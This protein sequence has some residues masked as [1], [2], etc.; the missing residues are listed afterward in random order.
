MHAPLNKKSNSKVI[1]HLIFI[2]VYI[3]QLRIRHNKHIN[4]ENFTIFRTK[5][6]FFLF[7]DLGD[8]HFVAVGKRGSLLYLSL[9]GHVCAFKN[10]KKWILSKKKKRMNIVATSEVRRITHTNFRH[11]HKMIQIQ[12]NWNESASLL[13]MCRWSKAKREN[14]LE[15]ER[16][17]EHKPT[18][19]NYNQAKCKRFD[20]R[21]DSAGYLALH[22]LTGWCL[23]SFFF[24]VLVHFFSL[25]ANANPWNK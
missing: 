2:F 8:A 3:R 14:P 10:R 22:Q 1:V 17:K 18:L 21:I 16:K 15:N 7:R 12:K 6:I 19:T 25:C 11:V 9:A 24:S 20:L 5:R 13:K 23:F 4:H